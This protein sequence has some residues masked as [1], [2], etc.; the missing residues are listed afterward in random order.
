VPKQRYMAAHNY[1]MGS[2]IVYIHADSAEDIVSRYPELEVIDEA[3]FFSVQ[4]PEW[5][6][7]LKR[8]IE[9]Y[10]TYDLDDAPRGFL[11]G[12]LEDRAL[13]SQLYD[14]F[15]KPRRR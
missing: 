5:V 1:G 15:G 6:E 14:E 9:T 8:K 3:Q 7:A 4:R 10:Q 13:R 11:K 2:I 12:L